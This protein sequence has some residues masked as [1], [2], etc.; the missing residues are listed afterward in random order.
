MI[1][2]N[3]SVTDKANGLNNLKAEGSIHQ[4]VEVTVTET[5]NNIESRASKRG[6]ELKNLLREFK[7][8]YIKD[9]ASFEKSSKIL[10]ATNKDKF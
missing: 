5:N 9:F 8:F 10:K 7:K 1:S 3:K 2:S 6:T 4:K